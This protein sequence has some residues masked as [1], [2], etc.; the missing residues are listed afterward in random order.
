MKTISN[1]DLEQVT[2]GK[3]N[4]SAN[5]ASTS[6][7]GSSGSNDDKLLSTLN[8]IQR[9][10]SDLGKNQN[11]GLFSGQNGLLFGMVAALAFSR[12]SEVVVY[13][14]GPRR[15]FHWQVW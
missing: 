13:G 4:P 2:G 3:S 6:G 5:I 1:V 9:S 14:G 8:S 7:G 12:R 11:N 15:G 10:L